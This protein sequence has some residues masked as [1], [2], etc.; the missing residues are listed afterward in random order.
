MGSVFLPIIVLKIEII[1]QSA[2][3]SISEL[4]VFDL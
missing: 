4:A 2:V 1:N 3:K